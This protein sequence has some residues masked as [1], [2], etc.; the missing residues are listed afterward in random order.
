MNRFEAL[1]AEYKKAPEVTKSRIFYETMGEV[2]PKV[3]EKTILDADL[4]GILPHLNL[5]PKAK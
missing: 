5:N 2:L 1:L 3:K 4:K